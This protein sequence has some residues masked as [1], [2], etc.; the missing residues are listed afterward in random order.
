ML[1]WNTSRDSHGFCLFFFQ[2]YKNETEHFHYGN[3]TK[4]FD[5][6][7][8]ILLLFRSS[9]TIIQLT[10]FL[11]QMDGR[12]YFRVCLH[13]SMHLRGKYHKI[14]GFL[15][16]IVNIRL[17]FSLLVR[18]RE[19]SLF[20]TL[21]NSIILTVRTKERSARTI[22]QNRTTKNSKVK[23]VRNLIYIPRSNST[24]KNPTIL[25]SYF[26]YM[27]GNTILPDIQII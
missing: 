14:F 5:F 17:D 26:T 4:R 27:W 18:E 8:I 2:K 7:F 6:I 11:R 19:S 1:F 22:F 23:G 15:Q 3:L 9:E 20:P 12:D 21:N 25:Q 13:F 24:K 16:N 10:L